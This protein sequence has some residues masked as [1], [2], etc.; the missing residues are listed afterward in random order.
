M[1][2]RTA[3]M[4]LAGSLFGLPLT[5]SLHAQAPSLVLTYY[6]RSQINRSGCVESQFQAPSNY[7]YTLA[8]NTYNDWWSHQPFGSG[9]SW[10]NAS[11]NECGQDSG[12][13]YST[14]WPPGSNS[15]IREVT[16]WLEGPNGYYTNY[17][18]TLGP[19]WNY[20]G[21]VPWRKCYQVTRTTNTHE[22]SGI[23]YENTDTL[24]EEARIELWTG[25]EA[26]V[27]NTDNIVLLTVRAQDDNTMT[28]IPVSELTA[29][30]ETPAP[31]GT[32]IYIGE[33][34]KKMADH[35]KVDATVRAGRDCYSY[36]ASVGKDRLVIEGNVASGELN[37]KTN[38]VWVGEK[39]NL[40]IRYGLITSTVG[41]TNYNWNVPG[42]KIG[43]WNVGDSIIDGELVRGAYA[44]TTPF[45]TA[46]RSSVN[47][48]WVQDT[49]VVVQCAVQVGGE[50]LTASTTFEVR[51]PTARWNLEPRGRPVAVTNDCVPAGPAN[52]GLYHLTTGRYGTNMTKPGMYYEYDVVD[53]KGYTNTYVV[54]FVQ[55]LWTDSR[56]NLDG[57]PLTS[58]TQTLPP[59]S[60]QSTG[61]FSALDS[62]YPYTAWTNVAW[63]YEWDT[64]RSALLD[65]EN[66]RW[67]KDKYW[68]Y[69]MWE[70][71]RRPGSIP[72]PLKLHLW[73]WEGATG[74][75]ATNNT[76]PD[77]W[78]LNGWLNQRGGLGSDYYNHPT[79][80][81][82]LDSELL[83]KTRTTNN[84][85]Y[86]SP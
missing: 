20:I 47:F 31:Q 12:T 79:W 18:D 5:T 41:A 16:Q 83:R 30:G 11:V 38:V 63:S 23:V 14:H 10:N 76:G 86:A 33:V 26:G 65:S 56:C 2:I 85:H 7:V 19:W 59:L 43:Y 57:T 35:E 17:T 4:L 13:E 3:A 15:A 66:Y 84:Y 55:T 24:N 22:A 52:A 45:D 61:S 68:S 69:L 54:S 29:L 27:T 9:T 40:S 70:P 77:T 37:G 8:W 73:T 51:R 25:G 64:P 60:M 71:K 46:N 36:A 6:M 62:S 74:K 82:L 53:L 1:K 78:K 48:Y 80:D 81:M 32:N 28:A 67:R 58:W 49:Q 39:I 34:W 42:I 50:T 44:R 21:W 75:V 72:V